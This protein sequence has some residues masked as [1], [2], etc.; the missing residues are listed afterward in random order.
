MSSIKQQGINAATWSF[1]KTIINP[2]KNFIVSLFLARLL[3]PEDF[4]VVGMAMV[5][6]GVVD[7]FVDFGMGQALVQKQKVTEEQT[8]TVFYV[9]MLM[10]LFLSVCMFCAAGL[11]ADYFRMP[12]VKPVMQA[13]SFTF[14]IRG[15]NCVQKAQMT[16]EL[17]FKT[18]FIAE[19]SGG[20]ISGTIGILLAFGGY[21]VWSLVI[22]Q[23]LGGVISLVI[24]WIKSDWRPKWIFHLNSIRELWQFGYKLSLAQLIEVGINRLDALMIGRV[25]SATVLGFYYR[26]GSLINLVVQYSFSS[27]S[28]VLFPMFSKVQHDVA[29][30]RNYLRKILHLTSFTFFGL[31]G[32]MF[33]LAP[34]I[35]TILF[36]DKWLPSVPFFRIL[37]VFS[38]SSPLDGLYFSVLQ[39]LGKSSAILRIRIISKTIYV[40]A[41]FIGL[42]MGIYG[43]VY[44]VCF[45]NLVLCM[46]M[47]IQVKKTMDYS[48]FQQLSSI[49]KYG[50]IAA[51][52]VIV[53][54]LSPFFTFVPII[55]VFIEGGFFIV[56]YLLINKLL[57]NEGLDLVFNIVKEQWEKF[58]IK[59]YK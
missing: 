30:V 24:I 32:F 33:L 59:M 13:L 16:K 21:G 15:F 44:G 36:S 38:F 9:N 54:Y 53:L 35:I 56:L 58:S 28:G 43:V 49:L 18:P 8:N 6:A 40:I 26:A 12:I 47:A 2:L 39:S 22:S 7:G 50:I 29:L 34:E 37:A 19:I 1:F 27:F 52:I 25:F 4:G 10:G 46:M 48:I 41:L 3:S 42:Q 31:S 57:H 23:L 45:A 17:D 14:I 20:I 51:I 5:F 11:A 55:N